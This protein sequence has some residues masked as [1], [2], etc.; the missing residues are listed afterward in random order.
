MVAANFN[1]PT[2]VMALK[3]GKLKQ[4]YTQRDLMTQRM[5]SYVSKNQIQIKWR[6]LYSCLYKLAFHLSK[7]S[8]TYIWHNFQHNRKST[9]KCCRANVTL[10]DRSETN[11]DFKGTCH[12]INTTYLHN[13][14]NAV[15]KKAS[16]NCA[17]KPISASTKKLFHAVFCWGTQWKPSNYYHLVLCFFLIF[18][19]AQIKMYLKT[20][21]VRPLMEKWALVLPFLLQREPAHLRHPQYSPKGRFSGELRCLTQ[22]LWSLCIG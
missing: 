16:Y 8:V 12:F 9:I 1:S 21:A 14:Q 10:R 5:T 2:I 13:L 4:T 22:A 17:K 3:E 18:T 19:E 15:S 7:T 11:R 6:K 20:V